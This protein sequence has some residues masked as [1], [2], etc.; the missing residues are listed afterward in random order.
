MIAQGMRAAKL[1]SLGERAKDTSALREFY[2]WCARQVWQ[3]A[4]VYVRGD[5]KDVL[6]AVLKPL[7]LL[8][9]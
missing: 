3:R 1:S 9:G 6:K 4:V 7:R 5:F 2:V 8:L